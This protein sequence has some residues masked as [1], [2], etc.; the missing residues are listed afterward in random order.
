MIIGPSV[1]GSAV[2][3]RNHITKRWAGLLLTAVLVSG[4]LIC[5]PARGESKEGE[6]KQ[7]GAK[8][9]QKSDAEQGE[10]ERDAEA[11]R[12]QAERERQR[13]MI[14]S[15]VAQL[16]SDSFKEREAATD[17]LLKVGVPALGAVRRAV[18]E[19]RDPEIVWRCRR[20]VTLLRD[21]EAKQLVAAFLR[22]DAS[23]EAAMPGWDR[24][25]ELYGEKRPTRELFA[26]MML[27]EREL[28]EL[29]GAETA[30]AE[31][32]FVATVQ[33][34]QRMASRQGVPEG[35]LAAMLFLA[36]EPSVNRSDRISANLSYL[37][38]YLHT[39]S[40]GKVFAKSS[41]MRKLLVRYLVR[42]DVNTTAHTRLLV[43]VYLEV[44]QTLELAESVLSNKAAPGQGRGYAALVFYMMGTMD[45]L[46]HLEE[47]MGDDE[48]VFTYRRKNEQRTT[49]VRDI[50]RAALVRITGQPL[51]DYGFTTTSN[52]SRPSFLHFAFNSEKKRQESIERWEAYREHMEAELL[53]PN[54]VR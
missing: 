34:T 1:K 18:R 27:E 43:G 29:F 5:S 10:A 9:Q 28:L 46:P 8:S 40:K 11:K 14:A 3:E 45:D 7:A 24:F 44:E 20:L 52:R 49:Q 30:E 38:R 23:A 32:A 53:D 4:W 39:R 19:S 36:A 47:A 42:E 16:G 2:P 54:E 31:R 48:V 15:L 41:L 35:S 6:K 51:G 26:A 13:R 22:G 50:A 21:Q 17:K 37:C 25:R 33:M 12:K